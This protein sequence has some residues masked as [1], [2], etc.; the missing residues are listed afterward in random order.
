MLVAAEH[1]LAVIRK[2]RQEHCTIEPEPGNAQQRQEHRAVAPRELQVRPGLAKRIPVEGK[3]CDGRRRPGNRQACKKTQHADK[4]D[5]C[6]H[7][8]DAVVECNQQSGNQRAGKDCDESPHLHEAVAA[9]QFRGGQHLRQDG[10][11]HR[12]EKSGMQTQQEQRREQQRQALQQKSRAGDHHDSDFD[13]LDDADDGGFLELVRNL[14]GAGG[15]QQK[16]KDE[17]AGRGVGQQIR[18]EAG[19]R[20]GVIRDQNHQRVLVD[21]IVERA[22]QLGQEERAETALQQEAELV[23]V[24]HGAGRLDNPHSL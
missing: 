10:V 13:R 11:L 19:I 14:S 7:P 21:I 22:E 24:F 4:Q 6:D 16:G 3:R 5:Q 1:G 15:E 17:N 18:I 9:N 12:A 20:R 8:A 23:F 2:L